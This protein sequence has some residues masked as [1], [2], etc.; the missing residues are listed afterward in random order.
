[1]FHTCKED[2]IQEC[3]CVECMCVKPIVKFVLAYDVRFAYVGF[4]VS[5]D[6]P[7]SEKLP[8]QCVASLE[9]GKNATPRK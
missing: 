2:K 5:L 3:M 1:M 6:V 4:F 7:P 9:I 8:S